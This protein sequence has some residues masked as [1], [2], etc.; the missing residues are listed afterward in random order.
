MANYMFYIIS[1]EKKTVDSIKP[2]IAKV[3]PKAH[4]FSTDDG[5]V[6]L[7][8]LK[9]NKIPLI[10][11]ADQNAQNISGV[12][13]AKKIKNEYKDQVFHTIVITGRNDKALNLK[14]L[15]L[16]ADDFLN[17]PFAI[18][19][20]IS[21][22]SSA[23][24]NVSNLDLI[25]NRDVTIS[26]L[27]KEIDETGLRI[28]DMLLRLFDNR[29]PELNR[30]VKTITQAAAWIGNELGNYE[31]VDLKDVV[32]SASLCFVG[33]LFLL[34]RNIK[35]PVLRNGMQG[36]KLMSMVPVYARELIEPLKG[37]EKVATALYH[38]YE[39]FDGSGIPDKI[40]NHEIPVASRILR[41][42]IDYEN[43]RASGKQPH[44]V[45]ELL[46]HENK[47]LY[48]YRVV[49]MYEQYIA[50]KNMVVLSSSVTVKELVEGMQLNSNIVTESGHKILPVGTILE[51][52]QIEKVQ[53]ILKEDP[54]IGK[55]YIQR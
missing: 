15:Q 13:L 6:L 18:D 14:S 50:S 36:S 53:S 30:V 49:V 55:I 12:Q 48:D 9:K 21:K 52:D 32:N 8:F 31:D 43:Y 35:D 40:K 33:K 27:I 38:I 46:E 22:L 23:V 34:D 17:N 7:N 51:E 20:I 54:Q 28:K 1:D 11:I 19:S 4:I 41:V 45:I 16:G 44:K 25:K 2:I 37:Y 24:N 3:F 10:V 42:C 26:K 39:N 29:V 47:R 5:L